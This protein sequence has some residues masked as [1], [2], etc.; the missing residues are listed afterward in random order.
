MEATK[1]PIMPASA[2]RTAPAKA[3]RVAAKALRGARME[4]RLTEEVQ[5]L[6]RRASEVTGRSM[7]DFVISAATAAAHEAIERAQ[8]VR[9]SLEGQQ[10][11]ADALMTPAE[12][13]EALV[14]AFKRRR[15]L[16]GGA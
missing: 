11:F 2:N 9:L 1:E 6:I 5:E 10:R 15:E 7:T 16:M 12:P 8:L 3:S 13:N 14:R 4:C